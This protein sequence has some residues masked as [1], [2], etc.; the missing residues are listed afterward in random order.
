MELK[1]FAS[2]Q[3]ANKARIIVTEA[4]MMAMLPFFF[5]Y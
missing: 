1:N 4:V 5:S 2:H 3:G